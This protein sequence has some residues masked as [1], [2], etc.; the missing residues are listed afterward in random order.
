MFFNN[1]ILRKKKDSGTNYINIQSYVLRYCRRN[2]D[3]NSIRICV[4]LIFFL[5]EIFE[6]LSLGGIIIITI[7]V[8]IH[9]ILKIEPYPII[10]FVLLI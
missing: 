1:T 6:P 7:I 9:S 2:F 5:C 3:Y 10:I 8:V 4:C